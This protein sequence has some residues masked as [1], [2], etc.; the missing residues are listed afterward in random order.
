MAYENGAHL[1]DYGA[2]TCNV[3]ISRLETQMFYYFRAC[4]AIDAGFEGIHWGSI[5]ISTE[6]DREQNYVSWT[7]V[8]AMTREYAAKRARRGFVFNNAHSTGIIGADGKLL[9]D[10]HCKPTRVHP[11]VGSF[12]HAPSEDNPQLG[13]ISLVP[14][15]GLRGKYLFG[16]SLGG[17]THSG[18]SCDSLPYFVELDNWGGVRRA[19]QNKVDYPW[20]PWGYDE[21]SWFANQPLWYQKKW[22]LYAYETVHGSDPQGF[23][24]MP[25]NRTSFIIE[26]DKIAS[27]D[28]CSELL[29]TIAEIW[30][31]NSI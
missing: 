11:P 8:V 14:P 2:G 18:W 5:D 30:A 23:F 29:E 13:I 22:L 20:F 19:S 27:F 1:N 17:L 28:A 6:I 24:E 10:F 26:K 3:D 15:V 21:I 12:D 9:L 7:R 25:C 31:K 4:R 16:N